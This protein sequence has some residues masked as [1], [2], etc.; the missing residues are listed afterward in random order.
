MVPEAEIVD[1][2]VSKSFSEM[3]I[4][5]R[6]SISANRVRRILDK[7]DVQR[8]SISDAITNL[9]ITKYGKR[10]FE[11]RQ[12]LNQKQETLKAIGVMLYWGEGTKKGF[13]V[14]LANSDPIMVKVYLKFLREICGVDE[15]RLRVGL[16]Y[17]KD[18]DPK[19]LVAFWSGITKIPQ[20]QFDRPFLHFAGKGSYKSKSQYG[21][22]AVRYSDL[23]LLKLIQDWI[24]EYQ[25]K[26]LE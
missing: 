6:F 15:K 21:T 24:G 5:H 4:A 8:R 12:N 14:A 2:Y 26:V 10:P 1:C 3:Q 11:L 9:Y 16:H 22:V 23:R 13:T 7:H 17:Y 18:H 25:Q 19:K 20:N